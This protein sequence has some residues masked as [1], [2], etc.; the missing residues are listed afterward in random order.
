MTKRQYFECNPNVDEL[1]FTSDGQAFYDAHKAGAHA[2]RL[3]NRYVEAV[4]RVEVEE[5]TEP[6]KAE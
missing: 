3:K 1:Y 2:Q 5:E 4:T 6:E